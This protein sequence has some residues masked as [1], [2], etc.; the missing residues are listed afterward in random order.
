MYSILVQYSTVFICSA[1]SHAG[2][3]CMLRKI[4]LTCPFLFPPS[5]STHILTHTKINSTHRKNSRKYDITNSVQWLPQAFVTNRRRFW[6]LTFIC[7]SSKHSC[8][9]VCYNTLWIARL[10]YLFVPF[11]HPFISLFHVLLKELENQC[12]DTLSFLCQSKHL[13][14]LTHL[15]HIPL[16]KLPLWP[17]IEYIVLSSISERSTQLLDWTVYSLICKQLKWY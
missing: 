13:V 6:L 5:F 15:K 1:Q 2:C 3:T 8:T 16:P 14:L 7:C 9:T 11:R 10:L 12:C 17:P 4:S